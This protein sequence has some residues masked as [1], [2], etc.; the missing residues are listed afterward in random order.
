MLRLILALSAVA[1]LAVPAE[2]GRRCRYRTY[3]TL[4]SLNGWNHSCYQCHN[5]KKAQAFSWKEAIIKLESTKQDYAAFNEAL[6]RVAGSPSPTGYTSAYAAGGYPGGYS[7]TF[8]GELSSYPVQGQSLYGVQSYQPPV[9]LDINTAVHGLTQVT[10]QVNQAGHAIAMDVS[11][12]V[13]TSA[14][15]QNRRFE[16]EL[17]LKA[18]DLAREIN[19]GA[20]G[21]PQASTL[22]FQVITQPN[23]QVQVIPEQPQAGP[24]QPPQQHPGLA[25]LQQSCTE[26]HSPQGKYGV[27]GAFDLSKLSQ[28]MVEA[29]ANRVGLPDDD[30]KRMPRSSNGD[31][32][33]AGRVLSWE[34]KHAI[35]DLALGV[36]PQ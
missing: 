33:Q 17:A 4:Y 26:C 14:A 5:S 10:Q 30:P 9:N 21:A 12:I 22:R 2:A 31:G 35:E 7:S 36:K 11:D 20:A 24:Q 32:F 1:M 19:Q 29:A 13:Q 16:R 23:G 8:A 6:A 25:V 28:E 34:E 15:A 27:H 3:Q 18:L